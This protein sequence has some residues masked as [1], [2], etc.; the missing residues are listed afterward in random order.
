MDGARRQA[1]SH[2]A[3]VLGVAIVGALGAVAAGAEDPKP[4][5]PAD[6]QL[7]LLLTRAE[8]LA[9]VRRHRTDEEAAAAFKADEGEVLVTAP[10]NLVPM[11]DPAQDAWGGIAAPFWA[12]MNPRDAWRIFLPIPPK[13]RQPAAD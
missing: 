8:I 4:A 9:I 1:R 5:V 6:M 3:V 11:R 2:P 7:Q 13:S 12:V 10:G